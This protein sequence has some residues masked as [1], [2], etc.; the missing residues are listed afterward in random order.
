MDRDG[1]GGVVVVVV[2]TWH[3]T[4]RVGELS[5]SLLLWPCSA[6]A[7]AAMVRTAVVVADVVAVAVVVAVVRTAAFS[8][9]TPSRN[10]GASFERAGSRLIASAGRLVPSVGWGNATQERLV[11]A[12]CGRSPRCTWC[13]FRREIGAVYTRDAR[14]NEF[15]DE[16]AEIHGVIRRDTWRNSPR[17]HRRKSRT[18]AA[19]VAFCS[20]TELESPACDTWTGAGR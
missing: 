5:S 17:S 11:V 8:L 6:A 10:F 3:A 13:V 4:V 7:A 20:A 18:S 19:R 14:M 15:A 16:F 12:G 2:Y 9:P 1:G